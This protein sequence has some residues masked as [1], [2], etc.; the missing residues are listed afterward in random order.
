L[1]F[2]QEVVR[3]LLER[4]YEPIFSDSSHGFRPEKSCHTAL[5]QVIRVWHG[6]KWIIE[7]DIKGF[8]DNINHGKL[9]ELL[10]KKI[11]DKRI[12]N[13]I[14]KMLKSGYSENWKFNNTWS[15]TPQGGVISPV[16]ANIYLHE[17]DMFMENMMLQFTK[18]K[19]RKSNPSYD[20]LKQRMTITNK[21]LS[22]LEMCLKNDNSQEK[23]SLLRIRREIQR[24]MREIPSIDLFDPDYRRLRYVRYADDFIIGVIGSRN[25]AENVMR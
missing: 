5:R 20:Y 12:I 24:K 7:F 22:R 3:I 19:R 14:R 21:K 4:I 16:L 10:E 9:I 2:L 13:I 18:G 1:V 23:A 6:T 8:F 25:D 17:L 11:D 15:G